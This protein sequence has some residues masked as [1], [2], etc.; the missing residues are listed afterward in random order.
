MNE[1]LN[2]QGSG[3]SI[4]NEVGMMKPFSAMD[5]VKDSKEHGPYIHVS[6]GTKISYKVYKS[7]N[8]GNSN[9]RKYIS[10]AKVSLP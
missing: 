6:Y 7:R 2:N 9:V 5:D 3:A 4:I 8:V 10:N 1:V